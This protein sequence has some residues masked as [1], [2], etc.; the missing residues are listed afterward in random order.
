MSKIT[1]PKGRPQKPSRDPMLDD[2]LPLL[3]ADKRS[4]FAKA[5][6]SGLSQSTLSN[7]QSGKVQRPQGVSIQ[8]AYK[9]LGYSLKPVRDDNVID[10]RRRA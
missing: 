8:M 6:V 7:W 3:A 2:L 4:T 9:M 5:A 10:M 1:W